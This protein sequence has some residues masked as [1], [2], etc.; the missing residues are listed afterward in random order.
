MIIIGC[1][2]HPSAQ[3][4]GWKNRET[5][6]CGER[7]LKHDG[8]AQTYYRGLHGQVV[9]VGM[10]A[11]GHAR[12]FE[13][14]LAECGIELWVADPA[15]VRAAATRKQKTDRRDAELL[16]ELL[17]DG[18]LEKMRI[19]MPTPAERDVRRLVLHRHRLVQMRTRV[20][21]QLQAIA[22][23]EGLRKKRA[24]WTKSGRE[25][26]LGLELMPWAATARADLLVLLEDLNRR[27]AE[28]DRAVEREA[29]ARPEVR[30]LRTQH[31]VGPIVGLLYVLT[32]LDPTRFQS[33]R[34]VASYLGLIPSE[35]SSGER[36]RL[37]HLTK[38]GNAVLRG[39]LTEAAHTAVRFDAEW[40]RQYVRLAM[41]KNRSIAAV[42]IAR[43]LAVRLWWMWKLGLEPGARIESGSHA[44]QPAVPHGVKLD[45][46]W[47]E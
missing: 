31:G 26:L 16:L 21:N 14:L 4:I 38:Q 6:E 8:E 39:L 3:M 24:L 45:P 28:L 20:M 12:W 27:I 18:R 15:Q 19:H 43:K 34:Q 2:F 37:G 17:S 33:S 23:N 1:D 5:G 7:E 40:R 32:I 10:E 47:N 9:R 22:L 13:R 29:E 42:A 11:T 35:R 36:Q 44:G 30:R 41:K 46:R 25:Q